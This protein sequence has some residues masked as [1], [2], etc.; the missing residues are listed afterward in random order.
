MR[1]GNRIIDKII[2][3][4][5]FAIFLIGALLGL[6]EWLID[7]IDF[8]LTEWLLFGILSVLILI[9]QGITAVEDAI[10]NKK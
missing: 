4:T 8:S 10:N 2:G 9:F 1:N 3:N 5:M 7:G 6:S